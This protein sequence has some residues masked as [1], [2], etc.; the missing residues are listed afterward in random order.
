MLILFARPAPGYAVESGARFFEVP[1]GSAAKTLRVFAEQSGQQVV[2]MEDS[3]K[4]ENTNA[5]KG[6][7]IPRKAL[8][9]MLAG[10][11]LIAEQD[12]S[13]A[14]AVRRV[15]PPT[16]PSAPAE[17]EK[18]PGRQTNSSAYLQ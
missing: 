15:P 4:D 16:R 9:Q 11:N 3:V 10:T 1:A 18:K 2:F 6:K 8:D 17:A 7:F 5:I 12:K 14:L 13:D